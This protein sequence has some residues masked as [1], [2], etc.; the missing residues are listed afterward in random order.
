MSVHRPCLLV[1]CALTAL[2]TAGETTAMAAPVE[3]P[4]GHLSLA[5]ASILGGDGAEQIT[6][7][8][9]QSDRSVVAVGSC[10]APFPVPGLQI[11]ASGEAKGFVLRLDPWG[12]PRSVAFLP[13]PAAVVRIGAQ[14]R[15][16]V[17][18][19]S[20]EV[21]VLDAD[22][23]KRLASFATPLS[24]AATLAVDAEGGIVLTSGSKLMRFSPDGKLLWEATPPAHG[25]NRLR[26]CAIDNATGI[27][28][29]VGYG[30]TH[31][32]KE[33]YKDP[34][35]HGYDRDGKRL[36]SLWNPDPK[37]QKGA[38][39]GGTGL[40]AD[41]TGNCAASTPDGRFLIGVFHDGGNAITGRDPQDPRKPID[42]D[43]FA[44]A[45]QGGPGH[46]MKGAITTSVVFRVDPTTGKLEKGT[47]MCAWMNNHSR[48]N[49]LSMN[50]VAADAH[51]DV[52]VAGSSAWELTTKLPWQEFREGEY[53][54]G[55][56]LAA[57]D[58]GFAMRQ[59]GAFNPG[60]L[61]AVAARDGVVVAA[62]RA[63]GLSKDGKPIAEGLRIR[64]AKPIAHDQVKGASDAL[65]TIF[66]RSDTPITVQEP[67]VKPTMSAQR[68]PKVKS[69]ASSTPAWDAALATRLALAV[70]AGR[71]IDVE[72][73]GGRRQIA[74]CSADQL[75]LRQGDGEITIAY[76]LLTLSQRATIARQLAKLGDRTDLLIA[77]Y[78]LRLV[79][80]PA[81]SA[82]CL[83]RSGR[84][85]EAL[86]Q[87]PEG[88]IP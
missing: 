83:A 59:C 32:G 27:S 52:Y 62:G 23:R 22:G 14:D 56:F 69:P 72:A 13:K 64:V 77:A 18:D 86:E 67:A 1:S 16:V 39:F 30:M 11:P 21:A 5:T 84:T 61:V 37:D 87:P 88:S 31:T 57:F 43:V 51:G 50:D 76:R 55:A 68:Q 12:K 71:G 7:L 17:R 20:G 26:A 48:A 45:Y 8:A 6:G 47:W 35:A 78:Y 25:G 81:G 10:D 54:G 80:D 79:D 49:S 53:R 40:M 36:W 24:D 46:G 73:F 38:N 70:A 2:L 19:T 9:I 85:A 44:G 60:D 41:G 75:V 34:Y 82:Y 33:P 66:H 3:P 28:V 63:K 42:P 65:I 15:I 58:S 4:V 29:V 74:T